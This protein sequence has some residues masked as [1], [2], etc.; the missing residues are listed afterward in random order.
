ME[1]IKITQE[2]YEEKER[3]CDF[4]NFPKNKPFLDACAEDPVLFLAHMLGIK[5]WTW[6]F[7]V[8]R[9]YKDGKRKIG[10]CCSRQVGKSKVLIA[11]LELWRHI[12]NKGYNN[13]PTYRNKNKNT[14]DTILSV[15]DEQAANLIDEI[16]L[17]VKDGDEYMRRYKTKDG[18]LMFGHNWF[19]SRI[20]LRK[21]TQETIRGVKTEYTKKAIS[22]I[23]SFPPTSRY[24]G[25]T[26]TG[27]IIDEVAFIDDN[28]FIVNVAQPTVRA[29]GDTQIYVS[30]PNRPE[31]FFYDI[32]DPDDKYDQHDYERYMFTIDC[33]KYDDAEYYSK[34]KADINRMLMEGKQNAVMREY[35]CS[36][37]SSTANY[38]PLDKVKEAMR[39]DVQKSFSSTERCIVGIDFGGMNK[40]HT[41]ITV[42]TAPNDEGVSKR[43]NCWRY[44]V[45]K[46]GNIVQD[47]EENVHKHFNVIA[48]VVDNCPAGVIIIQQMKARNWNVVEF[49]FNRK[50]K[51]EY[52]SKFRSKLSKG[53]LVSYEDGWLYEEFS[54]YSDDLKPLGSG[55]DDGIDSWMLATYPFLDDK[56]QDKF[57][58]IGGSNDD[59]LKAAIQSAE[60]KEK[61]K[62]HFQGLS[63]TF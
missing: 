4:V 48:T 56:P 40:S 8:L 12:F 15:T 55:S 28:E 46:E 22:Q 60:F 18:K 23:K 1:P 39:P 27:L 32:I 19:S 59:E 53:L 62:N 63:Q 31:G 49:N 21:S 47:V 33:I 14:F 2:M 11:G 37:V 6:Q 38:F 36:F 58:V 17:L 34:V 5:P 52:M 54:S 41:V 35:Y 50:S 10:V 24:R 51:G 26:S 3:Y 57:F 7:I 42:V 16:K 30:T 44:P 20:D 61:Y 45:K 43:I 13:Y 25:T 9:D 29:I